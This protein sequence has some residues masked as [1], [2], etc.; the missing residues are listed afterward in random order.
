[1]LA[2][3]GVDWGLMSG[4]SDILF[5]AI[6]PTVPLNLVKIASTRD[7]ATIGWSAPSDSGGTPI[8]NYLIFSNGGS[9]STY[10]MIFNSTDPTIYTYLHSNLAPTGAL[11]SY[12][13]SA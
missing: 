4:S 9:G 2:F 1:V 8:K 7:S 6:P 3:N 12:Q 10:T 13:V 11:Y 5:A